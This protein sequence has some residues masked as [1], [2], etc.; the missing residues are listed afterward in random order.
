V[1]PENSHSADGIMSAS[2]DLRAGAIALA[3]FTPAQ[4]V[5]IQQTVASGN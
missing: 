5:A 4:A 1:L 3:A 2:L